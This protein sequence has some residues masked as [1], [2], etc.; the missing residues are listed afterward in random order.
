MLLLATVL[1]TFTFGVLALILVM[2]PFGVLGFTLAQ[3]TASDSAAAI[4]HGCRPHGLI[5][6]PAILI[7]GA[8]A[9]RLGSTSP[10]RR[11]CAGGQRLAA[12]AGRHAPDRPRRGPAMIIVAGCSKSA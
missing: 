8:A 9:L 12:R 4:L 6:I 7:A 11:R 2:L 10:A 3:V 5:E 1:A